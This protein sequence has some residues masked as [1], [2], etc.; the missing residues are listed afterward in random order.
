VS[1]DRDD[2]DDRAP[3]DPRDP[4]GD[5]R[6][7]APGHAWARD[8][9]VPLVEFHR[10]LPSTSDRLRDMARAGAQPFTTVVSESQT[11]GRGREGR[12]WRSAPGAGL[13]MSVLLPLP[14]GG[15]PGVTPLAVGVAVAEAL[16]ALGI[17]QVRLK[18]PNDVLVQRRKVAGILCE[19][20]HG[21]DG[22]SVG[23]IAGVGVNLL[24]PGPNDDA[25][26]LR[27][28]WVAESLGA[29][30][31]PE[32]AELAR[33]LIA[34]MRGVADPPPDRLVGALREQWE[35]RD[36]LAGRWVVVSGG[37]GAAQV[38]RAV[39]VSEDGALLVRPEGD[40]GADGDPE[41]L[42]IRGGSVRLESSPGAEPRP[43]TRGASEGKVS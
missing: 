16:E 15:P 26:G 13:W 29:G 34:G 37:G 25:A 9:G 39:G 32:V 17:E 14:P 10:S 4:R 23:I 18:W 38:G 30:R 28:G 1:D 24:D 2:R 7:H 11:A 8:L 33:L 36:L 27:P 20:A 21:P 5:E 19:V 22:G 31:V 40:R 42:E 3:R 41:L 35:A 12:L 6:G 43:V